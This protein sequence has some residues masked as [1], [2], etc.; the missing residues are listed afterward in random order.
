MKVGGTA[1]FRKAVFE[2][3]VDFRSADITSNFEAQEAKFQNKETEANFNSIKVGGHAFFNKVVFEG[4]VNFVSA[5]IA[6]NFEADEAKFEDKEQE[7]NFGRL[8]VGGSA[9][10]WDAVFEGPVNFRYADFA[11][12]I[13]SNASRPK[14]AAQFDMQGMSYKYIRAVKGN[15]PESHKALLKLAEQSAYTANV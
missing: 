3:P 11:E 6:G 4:P 8:K 13:L 5:N 9:F 12:L 1:F 14:V 15:E 10:F 7:A 2:G